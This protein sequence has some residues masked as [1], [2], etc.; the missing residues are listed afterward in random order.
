[1]EFKYVMQCNGNT[2]DFAIRL[3]KSEAHLNDLYF[4]NMEITSILL[5][6]NQFRD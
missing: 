4:N 6:D 2:T 5:I 3:N 1:M